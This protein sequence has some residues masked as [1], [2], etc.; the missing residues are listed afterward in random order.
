MHVQPNLCQ[1]NI[2]F[3]HSKKTKIKIKL[4]IRL[5]ALRILIITAISQIFFVYTYRE[6][7]T[8]ISAAVLRETNLI[9]QGTKWILLPFNKKN[10]ECWENKSPKIP[11]LWECRERRTNRNL[12]WWWW[13]LQLLWRA[14]YVRIS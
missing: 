14:Q 1:E 11:R 4:K 5:I 3:L 10:A 6:L 2:N 7:R 12:L 13:L 8:K 9:V